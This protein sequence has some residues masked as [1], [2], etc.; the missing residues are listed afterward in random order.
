M[1]NKGIFKDDIILGILA[2][3]VGNI[4]KEIITWMFHFLGYLRYTFV[5]LAAGSFVPSEFI[6]NPVSLATGVIS[7][8]VM[9][10][11]IGILSVY[12]IRFTG[13]KY[14]IIKSLFLSAFFYIILYGALMAFDV[15]GVSLLTPLPSLLLF[16]PHLAMGGGIG[17]FI[18]KYGLTLN[19]NI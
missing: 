13:E 11:V 10:G 4:P 8:W 7:D 3:F 1:I 15:T 16:F 9:V 2:G 5:H 12:L 17:W 19:R 18:K 6:D 14:P